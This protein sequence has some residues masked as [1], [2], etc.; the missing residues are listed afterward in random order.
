V[1]HPTQ[2]TNAYVSIGDPQWYLRIGVKDGEV[3]CLDWKEAWMLPAPESVEQ[4]IDRK[5]LRT[6]LHKLL[7][8]ARRLVP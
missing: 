6:Y 2:R 1:K 3:V 8:E 4:L 7:R 5:T